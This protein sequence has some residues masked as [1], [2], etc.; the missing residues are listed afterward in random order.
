M[1]VL[2]G[3]TLY[4]LYYDQSFGAEKVVSSITFSYPAGN[5]QCSSRLISL[6]Y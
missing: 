3:Q 4:S 6:G 5:M 1:V 2:P